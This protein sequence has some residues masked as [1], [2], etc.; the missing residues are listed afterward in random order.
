MM[1]QTQW[2]GKKIPGKFSATLILDENEMRANSDIDNRIKVCA[3]FAKYLELITDDSIKYMRK[4][5]IEVGDKSMA[6]EG[7]RLILRSME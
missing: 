2:R 5:T 1:S 4:V 3:D 7:A 6:P